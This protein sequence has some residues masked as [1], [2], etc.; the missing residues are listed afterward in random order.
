MNYQNIQAGFKHDLT[1]YA[2]QIGDGHSL[3][4]VSD[5]KCHLS[6]KP[7]RTSNDH[8]KRFQVEFYQIGDISVKHNGI[9]C[10]HSGSTDRTEDLLLPFFGGG[11]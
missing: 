11:G 4:R 7:E 5:T 10:V 6:L 3:V 9:P 2:T 8:T 1:V